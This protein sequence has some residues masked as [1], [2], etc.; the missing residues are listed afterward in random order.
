MAGREWT[1]GREGG[2]GGWCDL[3]GDLGICAQQ[4]VPVRF[5]CESGS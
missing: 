3:G 2:D 1:R 4:S 5:I